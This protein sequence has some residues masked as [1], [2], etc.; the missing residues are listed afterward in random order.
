MQHTISITFDQDDIATGVYQVRLASAS[1]SVDEFGVK[2]L[3]NSTVIVPWGTVVTE[4]ATGVYSYEFTV[5]NGHLYDVSW[6]IIVN[7]GESPTYRTYQIGP[8][9]SINN[10]DVRA[11]SSFSGSFS[12]G[13]FATLMLKV[14]SFNGLPIDAENIYI[15]IYEPDGT[16]TTLDNNIPESVSTGY[17]AIDWNVPEDQV[18]G[19]HRVLW[20]YIIDD[21]Q[22]AEI[23]NITISEKNANTDT[24]WYSGRE[25]AFR[26]ALEY[27]IK[28]AQNIPVYY[29]QAKP[30]RDNKK[31]YFTFK[32]W[33]QSAGVKIYKNDQIVNS[34]VEVDF[35]KGSITFDNTLLSQETVHADYNFRWFSDEELIRFVL[36]AVQNIN[37]YPPHSGYDVGNVPDRYAP[38]VLY[39]AAKDALR[40]LMMCLNFQQPSQVFGG[41][42][43]AQQ[44]FSNFETLKQNYEKDWDKIL[45]NKKYG[46]WPK[47]RTTT[48]PEYTLPGGRSL[49]PDTELL[50][51]PTKSTNN[52]FKSYY[53][54]TKIITAQDVKTCSIKEVYELFHNGYDVEILSQN[55]ITG[56]LVFSPINYC[57]ESGFK[58]I[59]ELK[60]SNGYN[61]KASDE[62]LFYI[63]GEYIPLRYVKVGDE[64]ITCDDHNIEVSTVKSI[65]QFKRKVRMYDLEVF[66][67]QN[68]FAN[69]IK[70]HNS[71][72]FRMLFK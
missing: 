27:H 34:G 25:L 55:D 19:N 17:Y 29:E 28:C 62:H 59:Y 22:K 1:P 23:Q 31:F 71:R 43:G 50:I 52:I 49:H 37:T 42:D 46:P 53:S 16:I 38:V 35:F 39:G 9:F 5:E 51:I 4:S 67:T 61:I 41:K 56:N 63:N 66:E 70:C 72:W 65:D 7:A 58:T 18:L 48:T 11:V 40:Q 33:N 45:E 57:W 10:D 12:Q 8:F 54:D 26:M 60:T 20:N 13:S 30:S 68:L 21:I 36:N 15:E 32:N 2:D 6:E 44:A 47:T 64:V 14:T 69:G 3:T 24:E